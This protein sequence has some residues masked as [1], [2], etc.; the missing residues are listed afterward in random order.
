MEDLKFLGFLK[1]KMHWHQARQ[2]VLSEN[3][4]NADTP[5]Y[6]ARELRP[7]SFGQT[8]AMTAVEGVTQGRTHQA[9]MRGPA[10]VV[11]GPTVNSRAQDGW[12]T[13]P[14]GN[15]VVLEEEMMKV[16]GNQFDFQLASSLYS[17]SLGLLRTAIGRRG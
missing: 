3:V 17:K 10:M 13:T 16:S 15:G 5:N 12:E 7:M 9:H 1:S 6:R 2:K 14:E 8:L 11:S 4:A